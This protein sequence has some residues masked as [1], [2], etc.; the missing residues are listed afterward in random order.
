ML[1]LTYDRIRVFSTV[2]RHYSPSLELEC[3]WLKMWVAASLD[4]P[5]PP[6]QRQGDGAGHEGYAQVQG[7]LLQETPLFNLMNFS[8]PFIFQPVNC[9]P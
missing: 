8:N 5:P 1:V 4:P 7:M 2:N 3:F 6:P 9:E